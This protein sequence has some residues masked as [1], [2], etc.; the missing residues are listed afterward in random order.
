MQSQ[1]N[2]YKHRCVIISKTFS[3]TISIR[4]FSP[5]S[6]HEPTCRLDGLPSNCDLHCRADQDPNGVVLRVQ[7]LVPGFNRETNSE[8]SHEGGGLKQRATT[9]YEARREIYN[10]RLRASFTCSI[11]RTEDVALVVETAAVIA[12]IKRLRVFL[13]GLRSPEI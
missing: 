1:D 6:E 8:T 7:Q 4:I 10:P 11:R 5:L 13:P 9:H 3:S 12:G 2:K